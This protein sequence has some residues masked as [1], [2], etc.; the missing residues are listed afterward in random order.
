MSQNSWSVCAKIHILNPKSSD[1]DFFE[2]GCLFLDTYPEFEIRTT[3][4]L[5]ELIDINKLN[6]DQVLAF[7]LPRTPKNDIELG[8]FADLNRTN[9][10]FK[11]IPVQVLIGGEVLTHSSLHVQSSTEINQS[12]SI[13]LRN[14]DSHWVKGARRLK[15]KDIIWPSFTMTYDNVIT[16]FSANAKYLDGD[17]GIYFPL[18]YYGAFYNRFNV[19]MND[20]RPWVHLLALL[21]RG[22]SQIGW[23]FKCPFLE[24]DF[25]RR[26]ICYFIDSKYGT[27]E[28]AGKQFSISVRTGTAVTTNY[29]GKVYFDTEDIDQDNA[30]NPASGNYTGEG[31]F[32]IVAEIT[33]LDVFN[34]T[35]SKNV[36]IFDVYI[37]KETADG[38]KTILSTNNTKIAESYANNVKLTAEAKFVPVALTDKIYVEIS[39]TGLKHGKYVVSLISNPATSVIFSEGQV[40]KYPKVIGRTLRLHDVLMALVH[41]INGKL[42]TDRNRRTLT[43]YTPFTNSLF[44]VSLEGYFKEQVIN[45]IRPTQIADS[46]TV[47]T[48]DITGKRYLRLQFKESTDLR[49]EGLKYTKDNPPFSKTYDISDVL[50]DDTEVSENP[51]FEPTIC[52]DVFD[53]ISGPI[54]FGTGKLGLPFCV[55]NDEGHASSNIGA[56]ILYAAGDVAV[57]TPEGNSVIWIFNNEFRHTVPYAFQ[58]TTYLQGDDTPFGRWLVYGD[59]SQELFDKFWRRD[60]IESQYNYSAEILHYSLPKEHFGF[61]FREYYRFKSRGSAVLGRLIESRDFDGCGNTPTIMKLVPQ[62]NRLS[63]FLEERS[64]NNNNCSDQVPVLTVTQ[65]PMGTFTATVDNSAIVNTIVS[66]VIRWKYI[67]ETSWTIGSVIVDPDRD[68]IVQVQTEIDECPDSFVNKI[69]HPCAEN[70]PVFTYSNI[71]RDPLDI[72]KWC[73]TVGIG[74]ILND[75][76]LSTS[77]D[78]SIDGITVP[79]L[80]TPGTEIC[81][82]VNEISLLGEVQFNNDCI[83]VPIYGGLIFDE[84]GNDCPS[85]LPQVQ[86]IN[87]GIDAFGLELIGTWVSNKQIHFFQT[88][89]IGGNEFQWKV[90]DYHEPLLPGSFEARAVV[91]WCDDCP[92]ICTTP[93][94]CTAPAPM[95]FSAENRNVES[96]FLWEMGNYVWDWNLLSEQERVR[97]RKLYE[98][99]D[100]GLLMKLHNDNKLSW[101]EYGDGSKVLFKFCCGN[102]AVDGIKAWFEKGIEDGII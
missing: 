53:I 16:N 6:V 102:E 82:I 43:V 4:R 38:I 71:H 78:L 47:H 74:G 37:I 76:I 51:L 49:I 12:Y 86:C 93:I 100:W 27:D 95:I 30:Y 41:L 35:N 68:F 34:A 96:K 66:Q 91:Y 15:C 59:R 61:S 70:F 7:D 10:L 99:N 84:I 26:L 98:K 25:G 81:G 33:L 20:M 21:Q 79:G 11:P 29:T 1:A 94:V 101:H 88:R 69:I 45:D 3:R 80:Y 77:I 2:N 62:S 14:D 85:N 55:D 60:I 32:D 13:E 87:L 5:E 8:E 64:A 58:Y 92:S 19:T 97:A 73:V 22:F 46:T 67:D 54:V 90:W 48:I 18:V 65:S 31:I 24:A 9:F 72:T 75:A 63:T 56:R 57:N 52:D 42:D 83:P 28:F 17:I 50:D 44:G 39:V 40:L 23:I 89:P 36:T